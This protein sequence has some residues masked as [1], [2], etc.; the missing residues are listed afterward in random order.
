MSKKLGVSPPPFAPQGERH[1]TK[2]QGTGS[3]LFPETAYCAPIRGA[4]K[5][6]RRGKAK[7]LL[8][9]VLLLVNDPIHW[10]VIGLKV[11]SCQN[12]VGDCLVLYYL[13]WSLVASDVAMT[14]GRTA[15]SPASRQRHPSPIRFMEH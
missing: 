8:L 5:A 12:K 7:V 10:A 4:T 2:I 13:P 1:S 14:N 3:H 11:H 6:C 9:C 15:L